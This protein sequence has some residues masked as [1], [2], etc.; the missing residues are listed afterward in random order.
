MKLN[1]L[2]L[3]VNLNLVI[4]Q[5]SAI[6]GGLGNIDKKNESYQPNLKK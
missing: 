4:Y 1:R 5:A 3:N 2:R 6:K